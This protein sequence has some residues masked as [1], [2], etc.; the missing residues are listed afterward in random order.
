M[1]GW[2]PEIFFMVQLVTCQMMLNNVFH[3]FSFYIVRES[4]ESRPWTFFFFDSW[5]SHLHEKP[6]PDKYWTVDCQRRTFGSNRDPFLCYTGE[7]LTS[8]WPVTYLF[9][10][11]ATLSQKLWLIY[12]DYFSSVLD[13]IKPYGEIQSKI[14]C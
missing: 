11:S 2:E 9:F 5:R 12:D 3:F 6:W 4:L 8:D 7:N 1:W 13:K 14:L 10:L